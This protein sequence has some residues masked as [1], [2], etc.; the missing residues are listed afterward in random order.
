MARLRY[1]KTPEEI[2]ARFEGGA[3]GGA[4]FL[5]SSVR[6]LRIQYET[7]PALHAAV[8][9][10]PLEPAARPEMHVTLSHVA[11]H[12]TPTFTFEIGSA[13]FGAG[14]VYGGVPGTYLI[15]MPMTT[16]AAVVGGRETYGEPK[17]I[18]DIPFEKEGEGE[19][20]KVR[21]SVSR[22]GIRT[23]EGSGTLGKTLGPRAFVEHAFCIKAFPSCEKGKAFDTDPLLV[24]L[25]WRHDQTAVHAI[26]GGSLTLTDSP[27]DPVADLPVRRIT[28]MEYE[29]GTTQSNGTVLRSLPAE[30]VLPFLHGRYDEMGVVGLEV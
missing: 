22:M 20:A 10:R 24:R 28:R 30:W 25:E 11:I 19:G 2:K 4:E 3:E 7:D 16:E 14:A 29:E 17:K 13:I 18:A 9:P 26:E 21:C 5:K 1:V 23:I 15:T 8:I 6:S 12:I 27:F